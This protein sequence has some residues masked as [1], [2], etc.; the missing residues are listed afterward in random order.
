M[1]WR[2]ELVETFGGLAAG[3]KEE[4]ETE[5]PSEAEEPIPSRWMKPPLS[6]A[7]Q[8][9][10]KF[11]IVVEGNDVGSVRCGRVVE[12]YLGD[13]Q[14]NLPSHPPITPT[15]SPYGGR[16]TPSLASSCRTP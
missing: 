14:L 4:V 10:S 7:E 1:G 8:L 6:M 15:H 13:L 12:R 3:G 5:D 2:R 16:S 9:K 11:I